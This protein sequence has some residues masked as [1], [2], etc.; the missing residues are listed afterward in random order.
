MFFYLNTGFNYIEMKK[1]IIHF[2]FFIVVVGDL[3]GEFYQIKWLDYSFKPMIMVWIGSYFL[4]NARRLDKKMVQLAFVAFVFSWFG[5]ILLM[6]GEKKFIFFLT[7]LL[8]FLIAQIVYIFLFLRTINISEKKPFLKKKPLWLIVYIVY[9]LFVYIL[10]FN[11][12]DTVL[13]VAVFIYMAALLSMSAM[14]LNRYGTGH[15]ASFNYV[16]IG[17]ILFIVSD[18]LIALNKFLAPIP[19]E[20]IFVM[21]TY[22]CAQYLIMKGLLKQSA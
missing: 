9:G 7:G 5:D 14:A 1:F 16:F 8:S 12:L 6:F 11:N 22:I 3:F 18:T 19:Y 21:T 2:V 20:G 4:F 10:L 15:P 17:S 13:K